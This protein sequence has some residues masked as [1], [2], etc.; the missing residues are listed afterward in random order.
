[1]LKE[2]DFCTV[3]GSF[4]DKTT[5]PSLPLSLKVLFKRQMKSDGFGLNLLFVLVN[6]ECVTAVILTGDKG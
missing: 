6:K 5:L 3:V 2:Q 1:M 4:Q